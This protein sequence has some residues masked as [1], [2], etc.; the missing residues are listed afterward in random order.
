MQVVLIFPTLQEELTL[1]HQEQKIEM[2]KQ[3]KMK[4]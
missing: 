2:E 1:S 4:V 3:A